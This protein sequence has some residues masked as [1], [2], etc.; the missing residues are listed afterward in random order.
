MQLKRSRFTFF[1]FLGGGEIQAFPVLR[2]RAVV[3]TFG[4][5][6]GLF[7]IPE[8]GWLASRAVPHRE[9]DAFWL[10]LARQGLL[11]VADSD[12]PRLRELA[13]R[14]R[15]LEEE[16]W[17]ALAA[18]YHFM[19][20]PEAGASKT[21]S[22][23]GDR[24]RGGG[25]LNAEG[26][27]DGRPRKGELPAHFQGIG[28]PDASHELP[29][30]GHREG[31]CE[32]LRKRWTRRGFDPERALSE[33]ALSAL[34]FYAF[35]CH[36]TARIFDSLRGQM[37]TSTSAGGLGPIEVYPL[38]RHVEDLAPGLYHYN[39]ERHALDRIRALSV[40]A[41]GLLAEELSAGQ[42]DP[43]RAAV[44]FLMTA[45]FFR[46]FWKHKGP[47]EAY[48]A[49]LMDAAVL[50]Q[51]FYLICA[52]MGL[53]AFFTTRVDARNAEERLQIDPFQ[54]GVLAMCGCGWPDP[55][56]DAPQ[57][58]FEPRDIRKARARHARRS[59]QGL[60]GL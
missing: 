27:V 1:R 3:L 25:A 60:M 11:I 58:A 36:R 13:E 30:I 59:Q 57:P 51:T 53:G 32:L 2:G 40:A 12:D 24:R 34:L 10:H 19:G 21:E 54:E 39:V 23:E 14:H 6:Q 48:G 17:S 49:L 20:R 55:A 50:G 9:G 8:G 7:S 4:E 26:A 41:A 38:I 15:R 22:P 43:R 29:L 28:R 31:L 16:G 47:A 35:G 33:E 45:R 44:T 46:H 42:A 56:A 18:A 5:L 37:K 52:E